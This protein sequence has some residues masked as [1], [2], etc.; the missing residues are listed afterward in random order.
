M[1]IRPRFDAA[2]RG[3]FGLLL[4]FAAL[5]VLSP[6]A[7]AQTVLGRA[8]LGNNVE[9][10]TYVTKGALS[11][12]VVTL[13]GYE[14]Y[15]LPASGNGNAPFKKLF[16]LRQLPINIGPRGLAYVES[17]GLFVLQEPSQ[18]DKLFFVDHKGKLQSTRT[19]QYLGGFTPVQLEGL[20]YVPADSPSFADR[21]LMVAW[22]E[23]PDCNDGTGTRI[24]V[25]DRSGQVEAEI[26]PDAPARCREL[27]GVAYKKSGRLLVSDYNANTIDTL[28]LAG[29]VVAPQVGVAGGLALEGVVQLKD[30]RVVSCDYSSGRLL[31]FDSSLGRLAAD[32][33]SNHIG[34]GLSV[35]TGVA[36]DS[37]ANRHLVL[38]GLAL[39]RPA[40]AAVPASLNS[41][42]AVIASLS[43]DGFNFPDRLSYMP[44]EHRIVIGHRAAPRGVLLYDGAG[45]FAELVN[46]PPPPGGTLRGLEYIPTTQQFAGRVGT[47]ALMRIFSRTGAPIRT[48]DLT[49]AGIVAVGGTAYFDPTHPTGGRFL[50]LDGSTATHRAIV[51]DFDGL[52]LSDFSYRDKLNALVAADV[53]YISTGPQAG[54]FSLV[55]SDNSELIVFSL[56]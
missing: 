33:R 10:V 12:H 29:H 46:V 22:D 5:A 13:D 15:G 4:A 24:E 41:A 54:A 53:A 20:A 36:W 35:P 18:P 56:N 9:D 43:S 52:L 3:A 44:D 14:V 40:V 32:D 16:D 6:G 51:T 39:L 2:A 37:D 47:N 7:S 11:N 23:N 21:I 34:F 17:E 28:D 25:I 31:Y 26:F 1:K 42:S 45:G 49:P 19:I 55:D 38:H 8:R 30:G 27:G 48:I 50:V